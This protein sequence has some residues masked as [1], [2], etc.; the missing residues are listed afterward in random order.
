[1]IKSF[2]I[3]NYVGETLVLPLNDFSK[4]GIV[5]TNVE[6]IGPVEATINTTDYAALDGGFFNS[7]RVNNR[8]I[9]MTLRP[10]ELPTVEETRHKIYRFFPVKRQVKI[11]VITDTRDV[12]AIGYVESADPVIFSKEEEVEVSIICPDPY[13]Y[14]ASYY[15]V[16]FMGAEKMFEFPLM[17]EGALPTLIMGEVRENNIRTIEYS[18]DYDIGLDLHLVFRGEATGIRIHNLENNTF[19]T[20]DET[21]IF[22]GIQPLDELVI[23]TRR[24]AKN[25]YIIRNGDMINAINAIDINSD[26]LEL[27]IGTNTIVFT[28]ETGQDNVEFSVEYPIAYEGV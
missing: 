28:A 18:G 20:V 8:N 14:S 10:M 2:I 11:E 15:S 22:D 23:I 6:G 1:M 12:V 16:A 9:V 27:H 4:S 3:T 26:W 25:A 17:N 7:S 24:G 19:L 13:F 21:K 5:I